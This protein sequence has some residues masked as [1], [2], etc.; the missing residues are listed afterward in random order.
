V[1]QHDTYARALARA[2]EVVGSVEALALELHFRPALVRAWI[3]GAH[4]VP[5][6]VFLAVV[7]LLMGR[8]L[9]AI[10]AD[11]TQQGGQRRGDEQNAKPT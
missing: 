7:D 1:R 11:P 8:G 3:N 4:E 6:S 2:A 9:A 5:V 10:P